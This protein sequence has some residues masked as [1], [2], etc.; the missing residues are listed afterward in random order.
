MNDKV[1]LV[2]GATDGIGKEA[3]CALAQ[4]GARLLI[5]G[6]DP[7][8][9]ARAIAELKARSGNPAIEFLQCD[10][11]SLAEVRGLAAS[12]TER[13][14]KLDILINNAGSI[15]PKRALS[16]DGY[17]LTFAVNHLAPFLLTNLL[18]NMLTRSAPARIVTTSSV[19]H[20]GAQLNF[21]DLQ[22]AR[23]YS[24]MGAYGTSKLANI[25]FTRALAKR[26]DATQVTA[27][28]LHPGL[29]RT[30]IARDM[31]AFGRALFNLF[32]KFA[33]SPAQGAQTLIYLA[34]SPEVQGA[35]GGYYVDCRLM[36]ISPVAQDRNA[37]ERLWQVSE[38]LVGLAA[39]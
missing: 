27:N 7:N 9:G 21:A 11:A 25:L 15:F 20:R 1:C 34:T 2:T 10:F 13:T 37:A 23:K 28:C 29:V 17:E 31:P 33:R 6:R 14:A 18:L 36:P 3:A 5:Q 35:S 38:E 12:V 19:A 16:K 22:A 30:S 24:P 32:A 4:Q 8:K 39:G 26:L